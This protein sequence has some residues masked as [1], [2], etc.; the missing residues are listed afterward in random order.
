MLVY[1]NGDN[2]TI[3]PVYQ[4]RY[5]WDKHFN[6]FLDTDDKNK[7]MKRIPLDEYIKKNKIISDKSFVLNDQALMNKDFREFAF[8]NRN[9]IFQSTKEIPQ[10]A[11]EKSLKSKDIIIEYSEGEYALNG[12]R[13]SP[14]SKSI[15]NVGFDGYYEED[16]GK[17]LCDFWDDVDFNNSQNEGGVSFP[18]GKKPELL[19]ARLIS[20]FTKKGEIVCDFYVGSGTTAAVAHKMGRQYI[21]VEQLDYGEND[22]VT[23]LQNV[24]KGDTSGISKNVKWHGGGDFIYC[25]LLKYNEAYIDTI[26]SSKTSDELIEV[27]KDISTNSFL[28]WYINPEAPEDALS[29]FIEIG[30]SDNGVEKQKKLL[31]ELLNKNQLYV[32]LSEIEDAKFSVSKHDKELNKQFYGEAYNA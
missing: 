32:N 11:K 17:L 4:R 14:L 8:K 30:K 27:F 25:E 13:L 28:K 3:N 19:L 7:V 26:Q 1:K 9:K 10:E 12:R 15:Y 21:G 5:E 2:I 24:I 29:D 23:R 6:T 18:S 31:C 20:M 16:F 22:S